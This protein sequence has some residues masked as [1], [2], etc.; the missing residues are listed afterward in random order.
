MSPKF[1]NDL[2][3]SLKSVWIIFSLIIT[4]GLTISVLYPE[5]LI[6]AAP[7]C[8]SKILF[9][10]ECFMCGMTRAFINISAGKFSEASDLNVMSIAVYFI[11]AVNTIVFL[12]YLFLLIKKK[13]IQPKKPFNTLLNKQ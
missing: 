1:K 4:T 7:V 11:F 10:T 6:S 3:I 12:Y 9:N 13:Y 2:R 8:Y 5:T